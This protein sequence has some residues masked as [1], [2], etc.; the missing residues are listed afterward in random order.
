[1]LENP[2]VLRGIFDSSAEGIL[3]TDRQ[4]N[5]VLTNP[6]V[7]GMFGYKKDEL[8]GEKVE[9]IL[10]HKYRQGH[11]NQRTEFFHNPHQRK[12]GKG[13]DLFALRKDGTEFP[14]EVSL[15]YSEFEGDIYAIAFIIDITQRKNAENKILQSE[16]RLRYFVQNT[17]APLAMTDRDLNYILVSA[18]WK[19][20]Y[21][22]LDKNLIGTNHK[23]V[24]PNHQERW[25]EV[26]ATCLKGEVRKCEEDLILRIDGSKD[27]M[28][29]EIHP[30]K[31]DHGKIGGLIIF[32]EDITRRKI[33]ENALRNSRKQLKKYASDLE[34]SNREL[35][36]F[37]Y[38]ASHDLQEPLRKIR[39]FGE[40]VEAMEKE[41]LS[42]RGKDYLQRM[43]NSAE[44]MQTLINDLLSYSRIST[45]GESFKAVDLNEVLKDV[46]SDLEVSIEKKNAEVEIGGLPTIH[47]DPTQMRQLFQNLLS[48]A[49]K[50]VQEETIPKIKVWEEKTFHK[51]NP[52]MVL[53]KVKDN[54]IGFNE[55]YL[56]KIFNI[57]QRL[58]GRKFPGSGIGLSICK[59]IA[60][61]HG[62]SIDAE[63]E[64]GKGAVFM[65]KLA[66]NP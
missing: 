53:I 8:L 28:R 61:R 2:K 14:I 57:F 56:D 66:V 27:W 34:K 24:F 11:V 3:I 5:I 21:E 9:K 40:R 64:E 20:D 44:R 38:V 63:S 39:T 50:F 10:P 65:I 49:L 46:I 41:T 30:W 54:G 48:N 43:R 7:E 29:W 35:Q 59:K 12:M 6:T 26:Y 25:S 52:D 17:P 36:D 31:D 4:G 13:L 19:Q 37:A 1:M 55:Q 23:E 15:S 16:E 42:D 32:M 22:W 33:A 60:E 51:E 47:A 58:Q 62:G 18:R 45:R